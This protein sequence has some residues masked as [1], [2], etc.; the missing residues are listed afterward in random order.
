MAQAYDVAAIEEKWQRHWR[1]E[2]TYEVSNDD[3][4]LVLRNAELSTVVLDAQGN[5]LGGGSGYAFASLPPNA[6][7]FFKIALDQIGD[8]QQKFRPLGR[9]FP[10][11]IGKGFFRRTDSAFDV[12][13]VTIGNLRVRPAG[14]RFKVVEVSPADR[15]NEF[16]ANKIANLD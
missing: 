16:A 8:T 6:R 4:R 11:P 1:D 3:P 12:T 2:G 10:R 9:G 14:R 13:R 15:L 5:V 7:E